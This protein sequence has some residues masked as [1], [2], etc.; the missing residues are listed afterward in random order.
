M[1]GVSGK[2]AGVSFAGLSMY[3]NICDYPLF[4]AFF[5]EVMSVEFPAT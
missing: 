3:P 2:V 1:N 4:W 5:E